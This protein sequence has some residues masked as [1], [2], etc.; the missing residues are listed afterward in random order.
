M[1]NYN[2][3]VKMIMSNWEQTRD[4]DMLLWAIFLHMNGYVKPEERFFDVLKNARARNLPSYESVTR[5]R[6]KVQEQF[7]E[8]R[9][10][11]YAQR[12]K[13]EQEYHKYYRDH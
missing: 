12:Q 3:Q 6:R 10:K 13:N 1:K 7:P 2:E 11:R 9:G 5:A 4:D 8:Y